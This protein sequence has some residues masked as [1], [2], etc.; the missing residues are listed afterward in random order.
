MLIA[1]VKL[2]I[3]AE[4]PDKQAHR[5]I[6]ARDLLIA[7]DLARLIAQ[8]LRVS[9]AQVRVGNHEIGGHGFATC[10]TDPCGAT[11]LCENFVDFRI[12][13]QMIAVIFDEID[14]ALHQSARSTQCIMDAVCALQMGNQAVIRGGGERIAPDQQ[15]METER[16]PQLVIF[17]EF[18][19]LTVDGSKPAQPDQIRRGFE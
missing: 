8:K 9:P 2:P 3:G 5:I 11:I 4:I 14:H 6:G 19:D 16:H 13:N 1:I 10:Q 15:W 7:P 12:I 17:K 18:R